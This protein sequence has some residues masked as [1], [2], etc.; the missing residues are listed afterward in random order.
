MD[1][2]LP[3]IHIKVNVPPRRFLDRMAEIAESSGKF[4]VEKHYDALGRKSFDVLNLR[5]VGKSS[6]QN[7][8]GQLIAD[9]DEGNAV[10][11]EIRARRWSP[12]DPPTYDTYTAAARDLISPLLQTYNSESHTRHRM[13]VTAK[14]ALEPKLPPQCAKL[15]QRFTVLAN[16]S[17]LHPLDWRRFYK[18]VRDCRTRS[19]LSEDEM[20]RLLMKEGFSEDYAQRISGIYV[21]LCD[22]KRLV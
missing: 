8:G 13:H 10:A 16:K 15:F 19:R 12:K 14:E 21:H 5:Y 22:F 1:D 7:V 6:H 3:P 11:V 9:P 18:F 17:V 2:Y 4:R 20:T